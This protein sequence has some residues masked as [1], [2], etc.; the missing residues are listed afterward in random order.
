MI[1]GVQNAVLGGVD[2]EELAEEEVKPETPALVL[3]VAR[4]GLN[5]HGGFIQMPAI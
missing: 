2:R 5:L 1:G 4:Q 3:P